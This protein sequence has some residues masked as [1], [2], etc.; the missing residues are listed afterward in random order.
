[1]E[2]RALSDGSSQ[3]QLESN[4]GLELFNIEMNNDGILRFLANGG[5]GTDVFN[6]DDDSGFIGMGATAP[7]SELHIVHPQLFN[8]SGLTIE[9]SSNNAAWAIYS[10]G[11]TSD[12]RL[13]LNGSSRGR[14]DD[15]SGAYSAVSDRRLKSNIKAIPEIMGSIMQLQPSQYVFNHDP[16]KQLQYGLIAQDLKEIFP[17]MVSISGN[18]DNGSSGINDLHTVSY[19]SLIP[20]LIKGMQEQQEIIDQ[21]NE[22]ITKL[23]NKD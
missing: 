20:V 3:I 8:P 7:N 23:E 17:N 12:L 13:F 10:S 11:S 18:D 19:S 5:L 15:V 16:E 9:N 21:L 2:V 22:R 4:N 6:I 14:F 1:M